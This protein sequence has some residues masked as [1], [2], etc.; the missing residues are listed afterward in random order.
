MH[1]GTWSID[2]AKSYNTTVHFLQNIQALTYQTV[3]P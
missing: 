1:A 2:T 3:N